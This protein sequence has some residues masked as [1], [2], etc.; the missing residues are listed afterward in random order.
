[1]EKK[2]ALIV[3]CVFLLSCNQRNNIDEINYYESSKKNTYI[4]L[5]DNNITVF[6]N[7]QDIGK[8]GCSLIFGGKIN[9]GDFTK[10][11][12][13]EYSNGENIFDTIYSNHTKYIHFKLENNKLIVNL[14]SDYIGCNILFHDEENGY[15]NKSDTLKLD[16][17]KTKIQGIALPKRS[18][19]IKT[20]EKG[21]NLLETDNRPMPILE[22]HK[23]SLKV[24]YKQDYHD[25][26]YSKI[27]KKIGWISKKDC[28]ILK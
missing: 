19:N 2:V 18:I 25:D 4:K 3:F 22:E 9:D 16:L 23:D 21:V 26:R 24:F 11:Y 5:I 13:L 10:G 7:P 28:K 17:I 6:C 15:S 27:E 12:F 8:Y 1:M 20:E 14:K